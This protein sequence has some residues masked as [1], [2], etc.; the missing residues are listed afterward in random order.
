VLVGSADAE[1]MSAGAPELAEPGGEAVGLPGVEVF[2][3]LFEM[4]VE[5]RE[6]VLPPG[7]HP[8]NPATL[9]A[10][11]WRVPES[12]WG[13]FALAQVRV[14]CRSGVRTRGLV[15]G[16]ACDSAVAATALGARWGLGSR[17]GEVSLVRRYD[18][19]SLD[20]AFD[21]RPALSIDALDPD[22]LGA[23]DVQYTGTLTPAHTPRG[24]RLVQLEPTYE[25][26]RAE[27]VHARLEHFDAEAWGDGRLAPYYPISASITVARITLP[28]VRFVCRPD[29]LAFTGTERVA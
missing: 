13:P 23:S 26:E 21:G 2:Q 18:A 9:V 27:R 12:P 5:A 10:L 16:C 7:L 8:T 20:V 15:V 22:P 28:P 19:V 24:L 4:R 25:I 14:G 6:A 3:A 11:A 29:V 17:P 1:R